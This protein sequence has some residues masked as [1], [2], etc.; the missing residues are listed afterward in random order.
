M[1][2]DMIVM[3]QEDIKFMRIME[4]QT[5]RLEDGSDQMP[6]PFKERPI[7]PNNR[8][9]AEKRLEILKR[10]FARDASFKEEYSLF[11]NEIISGNKAEPIYGQETSKAGEVWYIPHF[12]VTHPKKQKL[13]VVFDCKTK[14]RDTS[15]NEHLLQG[16]DHMNSLLGILCRF[17][18]EAVPI[19]CD[20]QKMFYNF[21]VTDNDRDY[22][23]FLW[24]DDK[25][26]A[27]TQEFRM[28]VHLFGATFS[29]AVATFGL[30]KITKDYRTRSVAASDFIQR[31]F[32]VD[33]GIISFATV[34]EAINVLQSAR[35]I[36]N[37]GNL[38]L[39]KIMSNSREVL[40]SVPETERSIQG[41][42]LFSDKLPTQRT[43]GLEW[44]IESDSFQ[45][46]NNVKDKPATRRGML[47]IVAQ[48][49]DPL[50]FLAPFTLLGKS[51]LQEA[52]R[53]KLDWDQE[54][55]EKMKEQWKGWTEA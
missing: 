41:V 7:L 43:L 12:A 49:Y 2:D 1:G 14:F 22:L 39:H 40:A 31:N 46:T 35:E 33:D 23:R 11:M 26:I 55:G 50:G 30:R 8:V 16:P 47:S 18:K 34:E 6:L 37:K 27:K 19:S 38:R 25:D 3:S 29:P 45:F 4:D 5:S 42:D 24:I 36:C 44:R 21:F 52:C 13:R 15:L 17:R 48:M 32:Y 28:K 53:S 51:I 10:R 9:Q 54:V 20:V